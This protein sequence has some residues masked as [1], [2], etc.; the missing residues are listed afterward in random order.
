MRCDYFFALARHGAQIA[1]PR[2]SGSL[3]SEKCRAVKV[4][5]RPSRNT[6]APFGAN[7]GRR[8]APAL[9]PRRGGGAGGPHSPLAPPGRAA[10]RWCGAAPMRDVL[11][12]GKGLANGSRCG[13]DGCE[14]PPRS[15]PVVGEGRCSGGRMSLVRYQRFQFA[16]CRPATGDCSPPISAGLG[17]SL[18]GLAI[19]AIWLGGDLWRPA[20][21]QVG[22]KACR[23]RSEASSRWPW[24][25]LSTVPGCSRASIGVT[26]GRHR[27]EAR[28]GLTGGE[29]RWSGDVRIDHLEKRGEIVEPVAI[30]RACAGITDNVE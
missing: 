29:R 16:S 1:R 13:F 2:R 8:C 21:H 25:P 6:G 10:T 4:R 18:R 11:R 28:P 26:I 12:P 30:G 5:V 27:A 7:A 20:V 14:R 15:V 19:D 22:Q 3:P 23:S 24:P 17:I 9:D